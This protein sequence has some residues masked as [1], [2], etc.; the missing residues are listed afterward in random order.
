MPPGQR[1]IGYALLAAL[2]IMLQSWLLPADD[3]MKTAAQHV[4]APAPALQ[5]PVKQP[6]GLTRE[7]ADLEGQVKKQCVNPRLRAGTFVVDPATGM[8]V[9]VN[10]TQAFAAA[11]IIKVPVLVKLL[12]AIDNKAVS[13]DQ[14]V[15]LRSDL[16]AGGSGFLQWRPLD[17]TVSVREAAELMIT[18]SDNTATNLIIDLLGG[19]DACNTDFAL[20]G[21]TQTQ[22]NNMLPDFE[23]T[24]KTSPYDLSYLLG[25]IEQGALI[26][27]ESRQF[28]YRIMSHVRTRTLLPMGLGPGAKISHK[29][30]DIAS[31][32]GDAGI[33]T[34]PAGRRYIVA[35]QV[36][37]PRN[38][39][40]GN[41]LIREISKLVYQYMTADAAPVARAPTKK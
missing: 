19:K 4:V 11:S 13:P 30:G 23:G 12:V 22:I 39:Q 38:D 3:S 36:E 25:K 40:R 5:V 21:L 29:T 17:S 7:L 41:K 24:N 1:L 2:A 9:D 37:R 6:F 33:V 35:V 10:G 15:T 8:Y 27:K 20:W 32:V 26:S 16:I 28:M 31:M 34:T 18:N 14:L